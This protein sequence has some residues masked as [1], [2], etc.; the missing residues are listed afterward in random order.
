MY[1][2]QLLD[3]Q[4][5]RSTATAHGGSRASSASSTSR[6]RATASGTVTLYS[7]L[8]CVYDSLSAYASLGKYNDVIYGKLSNAA[9][10]LLRPGPSSSIA[11]KTQQQYI[12]VR[13]DQVFT[14]LTENIA[15]FA[16]NIIS[17]SKYLYMASTAP[18]SSSTVVQGNGGVASNLL[19]ALQIRSLPALEEVML[20]FQMLAA[21]HVQVPIDEQTLQT[22]I[23]LATL[24][25]SLVSEDSK[26]SDADITT[27]KLVE[28]GDAIFLPDNNHILHAIN[29]DI[30][31]D[32]APWLA[33]RLDTSKFALLH[34][35]VPDY[36]AAILGVR[37]LSE[38]VVERVSAHSV[39]AV[40]LSGN[41]ANNKSVV[42]CVQRWNNN[43]HRPA[44]AGALRKAVQTGL[45]KHNARQNGSKYAAKQSAK[46]T[47]MTEEEIIHKIFNLHNCTIKLA[48][49]IRSQFLLY[50]TRSLTSS[51]VE[52]IDV[53]KTPEGSTAV[54]IDA[55]E[56]HTNG[57]TLYLLYQQNPSD[58]TQFSGTVWK[59]RW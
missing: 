44:Y 15:P 14:G 12:F 58:P 22:V 23:H 38:A 56:N 4:V 51:H 47:T 30:Y 53:T 3:S 35:T 6:Y 59:K 7:Q 13:P 26:S 41:N 29:T 46:H 37:T 17:A 2:L 11:A 16:Y 21:D 10:L 40:E 49:S 36:V 39:R 52:P 50:S 42:E 32:D 18:T 33:N 57:P 28:Y 54:F 31:V 20:W 43:L 19:S 1:S 25:C 34:K 27:V 8:D 5:P 45:G 55:D 48:S 9:C 24:T